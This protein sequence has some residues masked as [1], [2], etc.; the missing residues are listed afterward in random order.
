MA[1]FEKNLG[2]FTARGVAVIGLSVDPLEEARKTVE[3]A[4]LTF[5]VAYGIDGPAFAS[6]TGAFYDATKGYLQATG[7]LLQPGGMVAQAV[8]STGPVGRYVAA[9][10]LGLI[11]YLSKT[12]P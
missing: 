2:E 7:F 3:R 6:Q 1:D 4:H 11:D 10:V 8:Y 5:P 12:R 9:D